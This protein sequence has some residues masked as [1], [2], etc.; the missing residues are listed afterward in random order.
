MI[1]IRITMKR[2]IIVIIRKCVFVPKVP[3]DVVG[4]RC[5]RSDWKWGPEDEL[6]PAIG[7]IGSA[8]PEDDDDG[9]LERPSD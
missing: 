8:G 3:T 7:R 2:V 6:E 4:I 5:R 9:W 1:P